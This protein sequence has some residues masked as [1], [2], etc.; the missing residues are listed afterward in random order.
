MGF[1]R[2]GGNRLKYFRIRKGSLAKDPS[3]FQLRR[4]EMEAF[5]G[6]GAF[7]LLALVFSL[8]VLQ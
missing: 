1:G 2:K 8:R 3:V 7:I 4:L 6:R 5:P